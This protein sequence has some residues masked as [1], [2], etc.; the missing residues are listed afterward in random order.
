MTF[1][2]DG[3]LKSEATYKDGKLQGKKKTYAEKQKPQT[4]KKEIDAK[5]EKEQERAKGKELDN[6]K[7]KEV[8]KTKG[9]DLNKG[10]KKP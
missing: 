9:N 3:S 7:G 10:V 4:D 5:K 2:P 8:L 6:A 1:Y